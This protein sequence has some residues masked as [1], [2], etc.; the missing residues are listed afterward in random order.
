MALVEGV[1]EVAELA[2]KRGEKR[3]YGEVAGRATLIPW[4][5]VSVAEDEDS[6]RYWDGDDRTLDGCSSSMFGAGM[7]MI[8]MRQVWP[9]Q[10][11][12]V[13]C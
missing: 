2:R 5:T 1:E 3:W 13:G 4:R 8:S 12:G 10:A 9:L 6:P 7:A 11:C